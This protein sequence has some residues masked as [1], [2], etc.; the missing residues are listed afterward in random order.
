MNK[1]ISYVLW[2]DDPIYNVGICENVKNAARFYPDWKVRVYCEQACPAHSDLAFM[3]DICEVVPFTPTKIGS[4]YCWSNLL[5]RYRPLYEDNEAVIF[6]DADS[7]LSDKEAKA[8]G[9]WLVS[10]KSLHVMHD[11]VT[12]WRFPIC[13]GMWGVRGRKWLPGLYEM[14]ER[15]MDFRGHKDAVRKELAVDEHFL[16][17]VVW[18]M[19]RCGNYIGHGIRTEGEPWGKN[20]KPYPP[21][22]PL[23]HGRYIGE[24]I[25]VSEP[26][27]LPK[28]FYYRSANNG[29]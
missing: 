1:I 26:P 29:Q 22:E 11:D 16:A 23:E 25:W 28:F 20:D 18:P 6:R 24:K 10:G 27:K 9:E 21:H 4:T 5:Q 8:V 13:S 3:D 14:F 7:R 12:H 19:F 17:E 15:W 2:G